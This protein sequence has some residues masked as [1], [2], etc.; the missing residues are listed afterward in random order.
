[1]TDRSATKLAIWPFVFVDILF[2]GLAYLIF[3]NAHRPLTFW[4]AFALIFCTAAGAWSFL[5]PFLRRDAA[6]LKLAESENLTTAVAQIKNLEQV[7]AQISSAT[8]HLQ[9]AQD[10]SKQ[11]AVSAKAVADQIAAESRAFAEFLQKANDGE[12]NHLRL[13][14]EKMR[15]AEVDWLQVLVH[16]LDHIFALNQA[17]IRSGKTALIEQ[18]GN[19]QNVCRDSVRRMGL[20]CHSPEPQMPFDEKL[21]QLPEG[22]TQPET[23]GQIADVLA[24]GYSYQ[25]RAVRRALVR[26]QSDEKVEIAA[27]PSPETVQV[28][29]S[30]ES[31]APVSAVEPESSEATAQKSLF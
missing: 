8:N 30:E 13:E 21:H 14:V 10:E 16:I 12:K 31:I 29:S 5:V 19:F 23:G 6:A 25:G 18:L 7:A 20:I 2:L 15:R 1:M 22:E 9:T 17:A 3:S 28:D 4:E 26:L 27:K 11:T 24:C